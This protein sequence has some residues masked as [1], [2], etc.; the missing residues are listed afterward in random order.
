[1]PAYTSLDQVHAKL[2]AQFVREALDDDLDGFADEAVWTAVSEGAAREVDGFLGMKYTVP[3]TAPLPAIIVTAALYLV[4]E[5]LYDRRGLTGEKNPYFERAEA[6]RKKLRAIGNGEMPLTPNI[7]KQNRT[8][9]A[10][11]ERARTSSASGS[12]SA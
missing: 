1:M 9:A 3:F 7:V 4:M 11:T 8:V 12:L 6:E 5:T 2:P 10:V